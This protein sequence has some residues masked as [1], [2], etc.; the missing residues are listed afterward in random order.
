MTYFSGELVYAL[1]FLTSLLVALRLWQGYRKSQF[2]LLFWSSI[3]FACLGLNNLLLFLDLVV[4]PEVG[5]AALR[6]VPAVLG[7]G[8]LIYGC[9]WEAV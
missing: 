8:A 4:F 6:T 2:R 5:F 3:C 1:C 9:I 7:F